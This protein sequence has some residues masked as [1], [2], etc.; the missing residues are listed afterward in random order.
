MPMGMGGPAFGMMPFEE[1]Y[2]ALPVAA[3]DKSDTSKLE[4]C[5]FRFR[6]C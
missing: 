1:R 3:A 5:N 2:H 6:V 4:V